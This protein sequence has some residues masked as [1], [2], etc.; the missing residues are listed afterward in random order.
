VQHRCAIFER[1]AKPELQLAGGFLGERDRHDLGHLGAAAFDDTND[2]V[3]QLC[4]F[5]RARCRFHNECAVQIVLNKIAVGVVCKRDLF[6]FF[7]FRS[8][9]VGHGRPRSSMRSAISFLDFDGRGAP[10]RDRRR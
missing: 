2:T 7:D 10:D 4:G 1:F 3:H 8:S 5:A 6:S 9:F